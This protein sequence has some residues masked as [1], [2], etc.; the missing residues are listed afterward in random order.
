M[1]LE[2]RVEGGDPAGLDVH[3]S[4]VMHR[5][6]RVHRNPG[7]TMLVIVVVEELAA[8]TLASSMEPNRPGMPDNI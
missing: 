5:G 2:G 8:E 6:G 4:A 1:R 3:G 7:M